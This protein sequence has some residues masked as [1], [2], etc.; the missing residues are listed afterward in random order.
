MLVEGAYRSARPVRQYRTRHKRGYGMSKSRG[1]GE[2]CF[3]DCFGRS[4]HPGPVS[5]SHGAVQLEPA[6]VAR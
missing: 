6:P 2:V 3:Q 1:S 4:R 5:R